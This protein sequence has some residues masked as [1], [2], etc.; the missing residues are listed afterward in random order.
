ME[1]ERE[2]E[3]KSKKRDSNRDWEEKDRVR[4]RERERE[5]ERKGEIEEFEVMWYG[6]MIYWDLRSHL[7]AIRRFLSQGFLRG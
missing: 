2:R 5:R 1:K 3:R 4:E 6:K 7:Q